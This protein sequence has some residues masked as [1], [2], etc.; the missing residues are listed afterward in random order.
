MRRIA[1]VVVATFFAIMQ[2]NVSFGAVPSVPSGVTA[3]VG[4]TAAYGAGTVTVS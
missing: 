2:P 3:R 4:T 1:L